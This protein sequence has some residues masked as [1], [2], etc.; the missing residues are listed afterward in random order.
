M[1]VFRVFKN[2]G[3]RGLSHAGFLVAAGQLVGAAISVVLRL[4]HPLPAPRSAR[5]RSAVLAA[6]LAFSFSLHLSAQQQPD[7]SQENQNDQAAQPAP[8]PPTTTTASPTT[9]TSAS[10]TVVVSAT[11]TEEPVGE[12]PG[13]AT[14]ITG[15]ELK[16]KN[17]N[18]LADA[19]QDVL[20]VDT[21]MGSDNGPRQPNVGVWGLKEFDALLFMVDGVPIGGPF[22]PSLAQINMDDIDRIEIV[23]GPQGTLYGISAFAGMVQVFTKAAE[24]GTHGTAGGGSFADWVLSGSTNLPV[25]PGTIQAYGSIHDANGWQDR[26]DYK[27]DQGGLRFDM[28]MGSGKFSMMATYFRDTQFFGSPLPVDP[29]SGTVIPGFQIDKNYEPI[30]ARLDHRIGMITTNFVQPF[31]SNTSL[32][33]TV[34]YTH[35]DQIIAQSFV[36]AV[37]GNTGTSA[38]LHLKPTQHTAYADIHVASTFDALGQHQLVGGGALTWGKEDGTGYGFDFN[39]SIAPVIV[40]NLSDIP[41]GDSRAFNDRRTF[42]GLYLNDQWTPV[43]WFTLMAGARHD[44]TSE[45]LF[46]SIQ[47]NGAPQPDV[48]NAQ[49][50]NSAFSGGVNGLVRLMQDRPGLVNE[51]NAYGGWRSNFKPAAPNITEAEAA[52]I[53]QPERT[54]AEEA[55]I[56]SYLLDRQL[57]FDVTYFHMIFKNLVVSIVGPDGNPELTNAGKEL[58]QGWEFGFRYTPRMFPALSLAAGYAWHN[59]K[60]LEFTFIDPAAGLQD[61]SG[62]RLE[63]TPR[64]LWYLQPAYRPETGPGGFLAFRHQNHRPFDKINIAYMPAF[65]EWDAGLTWTF[66]EHIMASVVGRNLSNNR[67]Y[68]A[69]SEIGDAQNYVAPPRRFFGELTVNF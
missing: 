18:N 35:D 51:V 59:A 61:A 68:V 38:G 27:R 10:E 26:T 2:V 57:A 8:P 6:C 48:S 28:P 31:A 62:Q 14:V 9:G 21:G 29:P 46:Q 7:A 23:K 58:F 66:S 42:Y 44:W 37:D 13:Q 17:V 49:Q 60:Y 5:V 63:L 55:G 15:E 3:P 40:P 64:E 56:K 36:S 11:R 43:W 47:E 53:L 34:N 50:S 39:F 33:A 12:V 41:P 32:A 54:Y 30:G 52:T 45:T 25:G 20:G 24:T 1:R 19:I 67:H 69:E 4:R 16:K 65:L 22:N